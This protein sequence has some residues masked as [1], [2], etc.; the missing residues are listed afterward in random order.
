M[1][2]MKRGW[3]QICLSLVPMLLPAWRETLINRDA[4]SFRDSCQRQHCKN[5]TRGSENFLVCVNVLG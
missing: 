5:N 1:L 3:R 2:Q 4:S